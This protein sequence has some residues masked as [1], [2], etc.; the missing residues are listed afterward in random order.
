MDFATIFADHFVAVVVLACLMV[1]YLIKHTF[2]F[3]PNKYIPVIVTVLGAVL[4]SVTSGV[5][6]EAVVYGAFMGLAS[7][8]LHQVFK[9]FVEKSQ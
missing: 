5:S 1:G 3:I 6:I 4:N 2:T 8:G 9:N 7:T